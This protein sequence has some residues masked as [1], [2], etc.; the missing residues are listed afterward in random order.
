M[1]HWGVRDGRAVLCSPTK[2]K[3]KSF[4]FA[5]TKSEKH[6]G[7][8]FCKG[9]STFLRR[10]KRKKEDVKKAGGKMENERLY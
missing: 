5:F 10:K 2:K 6:I 4:D 3:R 9:Q 8:Y 1:P 7:H